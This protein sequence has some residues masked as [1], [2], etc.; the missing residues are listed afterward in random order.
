M[1]RCEDRP[2]STDRPR[3]PRRAV[4]PSGTVGD[5]ESVLRSV[6]KVSAPEPTA[7]PSDDRASSSPPRPTATGPAA[8]LAERVAAGRRTGPADGDDP[9]LAG[10]SLD[11]GDL[12][13]GERVEDS[14][15]DRL[16]RDKPPHW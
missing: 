2:V 1:P 11:D 12:G 16:R 5:D 3:A 13:W 15:D 4:R 7:G 10:R 14:N 8:D 6:L 9:A